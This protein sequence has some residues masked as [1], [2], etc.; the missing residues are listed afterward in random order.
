MLSVFE[1]D[2][3]ERMLRSFADANDIGLDISSNPMTDI[4]HFN[5]HLDE[6]TICP[7]AISLSEVSDDID[8]NELYEIIIKRV[9]YENRWNEMRKHKEERMLVSNEILEFFNSMEETSSK[10]LQ[11]N[12]TTGYHYVD[13]GESYLPAIQ[14][15]I[16]NDPATIVIWSD[17]IKTVVKCD[18]ESFDPEKGLAMA[19]AKRALGNNGNYYETFK[20]W[21]PEKPKPVDILQDMYR[22]KLKNR[23]R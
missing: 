15:V 10:R 4:I 7:I 13:E 2:Y 1:R 23:R 6:S 3:L 17:G 22:S 8:I 18:C 11:G 9:I 5:F 21:L 19:I 14:K 12:I 20:K 16:F